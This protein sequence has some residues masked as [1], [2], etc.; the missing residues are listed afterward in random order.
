MLT[1]KQGDLFFR[2]MDALRTMPSLLGIVS[3]HPPASASNKDER[4]N[5]KGV[6][7]NPVKGILAKRNTKCDK[8]RK[9]RQSSQDAPHTL[10]QTRKPTHCISPMRTQS[11][12]P[13]PR[14]G[15]IFI[16][17][18]IQMY[19]RNLWITFNIGRGRNT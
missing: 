8:K 10:T 14:Q 2:S 13:L 6:T 17:N 15:T 1:H 7:R 3:M 16:I 19:A 5:A 9:S 11:S 4:D 18:H 12:F